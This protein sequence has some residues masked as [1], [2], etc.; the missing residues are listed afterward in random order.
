M[1]CA[2]LICDKDFRNCQC[3]L[4][5]NLNMRSFG[6]NNVLM[7]IMAFAGSK[8]DTVLIHASLVRK[9]EYGYAF[10]ALCGSG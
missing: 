9:H 3:A 2:L 8:R 7:L 4:S 6:L 1:P 5:G 10:F